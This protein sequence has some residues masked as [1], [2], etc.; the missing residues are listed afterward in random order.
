V[1]NFKLAFTGFAAGA[2][3]LTAAMVL[4]AGSANAADAPRAG[5]QVTNLD[6]DQNLFVSPPGEPYTAPASDPYPVVKWFKKIDT[7]GDGKLDIDEF[8]ADATAFFQVLDRNHDGMISTQE[9]YIYEH[10]IVPELLAPKDPA[11]TDLYD[12]G[13][14]QK[15]NADEGATP[16]GFFEEPE[17][18]TAADR[19]FDS[20][21]T[22]KEFLDQSDRH[23]RALDVKHKGYLTLDD[24]PKT[25][26]EKTTNTK[27]TP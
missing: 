19:K 8:R 11:T 16:Y 9:V 6:S 17:P 22:L 18:V 3:A 1:T 10:Y 13:D 21:I 5:A 7:N 20:R 26:V 24:L 4:T 25:R 12:G 2:T 14:Q 27:R 23:F 15:L